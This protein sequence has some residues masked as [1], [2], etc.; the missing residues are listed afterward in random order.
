[1]ACCTDRHEPLVTCCATQLLR[2][3]LRIHAPAALVRPVHRCAVL[4]VLMYSHV[5]CGSCAAASM[6]VQRACG[7]VPEATDRKSVVSGKRV[8][9]REEPGGSRISKQKNQINM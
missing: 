3:L 4:G 7:R 1:M 8:S 5:H 9:V 2:P 6:C